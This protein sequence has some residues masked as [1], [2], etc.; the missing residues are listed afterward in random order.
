MNTSSSLLD[1]VRAHLTA[2]RVRE[3]VADA[4]RALQAD[5]G[6]QTI[7]RVLA[8]SLRRHST[9]VA[10]DQAPLVHRLLK[11]SNVSP[12]DVSAAGWY[13]A[14][15]C[16]R[17][18]ATDDG[19]GMAQH[20]EDDVFAQDLLG[21]TYVNDLEAERKLTALRRW[22][23]LSGRWRDF[24]RSAAAFVDQARHNGGAWLFDGEER[25]RLNADGGSPFVQAYGLDTSSR[26]ASG[27]FDHPTTKAVAEQ[28]ENWPYPTWT[29]LTQ[30]IP[31]SLAEQ[32]K[33]ID[34]EGPDFPERPKILIAGCGTG[35]E[36]ALIALRHPDAR[37]TAID[38]S[39]AS[40]AYA[41]ERSADLGLSDI[42]FHQ[43]DLH[44]AAEL[45]IR[46]DAIFTSG[47]LH[48]LPDPEA[49]WAAL[50][51]TL[52][53][54]GVMKVMLYSKVARMRIQAARV[55]LADFASRQIDADLLRAVRAKLIAMPQKFGTTSGDF[56][57]LGGVRDLLLH[58]HEDP[59]TVARIGRALD[60]LGL[61]LLQFRLPTDAERARYRNAY[62]D[63][64]LF[65]DMAAWS[66]LEKEKPFLFGA[67]YDF[68]CRK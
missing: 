62:P 15:Q 31:K 18:F 9:V 35:R 64:P 23:L 59:F 57:T 44:R 65:R 11:D 12:E 40:L 3:G 2:G 7:K 52:A 1:S 51:A 61:K 29:R 56:F 39:Q 34:P 5:P 14:R 17:L 46:F 4:F 63:D 25:A 37:V 42:A 45:G 55:L 19:A 66:S 53:P 13:L 27:G 38:I 30:P 43:L 48:H 68:W 67:M 36:A 16:G 8:Q 6:N 26:P 60:A 49:G 54:G 50:V 33:A 58:S 47:V 28:Y 24:P 10:P 22:L 21:E 20:L 32:V 41:R